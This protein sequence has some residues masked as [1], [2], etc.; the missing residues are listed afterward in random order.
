MRWNWSA[1]TVQVRTQDLQNLRN[2]PFSKQIGMLKAKG[3]DVVRGDG[4]SR[5]TGDDLKLADDGKA[6]RRDTGRIE[7]LAAAWSQPA[8]R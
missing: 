1:S 5:R 3:E 4:R 2:H 7:P 8:A 6:A